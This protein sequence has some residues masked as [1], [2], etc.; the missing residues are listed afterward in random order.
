MVQTITQ[1]GAPL[2]NP[3][4]EGL[5]LMATTSDTKGGLDQVFLVLDHFL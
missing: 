4:Q 5:P 3:L 1:H 2:L